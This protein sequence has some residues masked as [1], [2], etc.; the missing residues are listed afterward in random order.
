VLLGN[1]APFCEAFPA[2]ETDD[3]ES[4]ASAARHLIELGHRRIAFFA[5][6]RVSPSAL[7]RL[8]GYR[9]AHRD[10]GVPLDDKLIFNAGSTIE[11]GSSA[12]L[13]WMQEETGATAIQCAHDQVA[14]G[15]ADT[16]LNQGFTIPGDLSVVGF[17]NILAAEYFRVPLTTVRQPK[18]RLG[19]VAMD[20]MMKLLRGEPVSS[21]RL[22]AQLEI[23]ASTA[24]PRAPATVTA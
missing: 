3:L 5:G 23:R 16:L 20:V 8:E 6:P 19:T 7:E 11:E 18:L 13:Q 24:P 22:K 9:R 10:A 4:S 1:R 21:Q 12:A 2:I 17:G 15:A 14:I